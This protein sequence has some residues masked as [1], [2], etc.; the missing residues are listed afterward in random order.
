MRFAILHAILLWIL[1]LACSVKQNYT[2]DD[3]FGDS[4]TKKMPIYIP[5]TW[6]NQ[7]CSE[8]CTFRPD[9]L[10][11]YLETYTYTTYHP[12]QQNA[13]ITMEFEGIAIYVFFIL[14]SI[15][16]LNITTA[17]NF[18]IDG[19]IVGHFS[20]NEEFSAT[21]I[22]Y[23]QMVFSKTDLPNGIHQLVV[24]TTVD[25]MS[26]F[27]CFDYAIYTKVANP[28]APTDVYSRVSSFSTTSDAPVFG[29]EPRITYTTDVPGGTPGRA[30]G[31]GSPTASHTQKSG[32][33]KS[34]H[35]TPAIIGATI[36]GI[37][38]IGAATALVVWRRLGKQKVNIGVLIS[39]GVSWKKAPTKVQSPFLELAASTDNNHRHISSET[40]GVPDEPHRLFSRSETMLN[41]LAIVQRAFFRNYFK[42]SSH[43]RHASIHKPRLRANAATDDQAEGSADE[44]DGSLG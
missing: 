3:G 5:D 32:S 10:E 25:D 1:P 13:S 38:L 43:R 19:E 15:Q 44:T 26:V 31:T 6:V 17:V 28:I 36:G 24:S 34:G 7:T 42:Q 12:A 18:T 30:S 37:I 22:L 23:N 27:I 9:P 40:V 14:P 16:Q 8:G 2:I 33:S 20:N 35:T 41:G 21:E 11:A 29:P 39:S 4:L